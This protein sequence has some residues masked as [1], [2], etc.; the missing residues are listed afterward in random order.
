M[1]T[2]RMLQNLSADD[3]NLLYRESIIKQETE[4]IIGI[5][6]CEQFYN[7]KNIIK[8]D[9]SKI[10]NLYHTPIVENLKKRF[11][12]SSIYL[13]EKYLFVDWSL[14]AE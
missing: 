12:V 6:L 7:N 11:L 4:N 10:S 9:M 8:H 2:S 5:I 13:I 14:S 1:I 3:F